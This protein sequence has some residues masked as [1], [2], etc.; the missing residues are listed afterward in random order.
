MLWILAAVVIVLAP[1]CFCIGRWAWTF[2]YLPAR[3]DRL[4]DR[5]QRERAVQIMERVVRA[6]GF[7]WN[8]EEHR[9][10]LAWYYMSA[11]EYGPAA[12]HLRA[13]LD[14]PCVF[15]DEEVDMRLLLADCLEGLG[16]AEAAEKQRRRAEK[17]VRDIDEPWLL[18]S[19]R[20][21]CLRERQR[22]GDAC[23]AYERALRS[24]PEGEVALRTQLMV[25]L[26][27]SCHDAARPAE[28]VQWA[29]KAVATGADGEL[30]LTA[31]QIAA[32]GCVTLG[33]LEE[34][35]RHRHGVFELALKQGD[36]ARAAE[37]LAGIGS[38]RCARG[39]FASAL[40]ACRSAVE[41]SPAARRLAAGVE[42][43]CHRYVGRW[44][45]A[46]AAYDRQLETEP[47]PQ[48]PA[49][50]RFRA[51]NALGRALVDLEAENPAAAAAHLDA[52]Y[53]ELAEDL[54]L[55]HWCGS[56]HAVLH[57]LWGESEAALRL[58]EELETQFDAV[59]SDPESVRGFQAARARVFLLCG[60]LA[61]SR[62]EW[63][64]YLELDPPPASRV[65]ALHYLGECLQG[66]G[67]PE[68]AG[69]AY[70]R[71]VEAGIPSHH[72]ALAAERLRM[73]DEDMQIATGV[74]AS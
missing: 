21:Q 39:E 70:R 17:R 43:E 56:A 2:F 48:P 54:K 1:A 5:G 7:T 11:G 8:R 32:L 14:S 38:I 24:A 65:R 34:A 62:R 28:A 41:V 50:R 58:L 57:A 22:Y 4:F 64:R 23:E 27:L 6:P 9:R 72:A 59:R 45:D 37:C 67:E 49:E 25:S 42:A 10:R 31:R 29:E 33:R 18:Y 16:E 19:R 47:F 69:L 71:A 68:E 12:A 30:L 36:D 26:A 20:G 3:A 44:A 61:R 15:A 35:E 46:H 55:V 66:A 52:A 13:A 53:G 63:E 60:D 74:G 73:I 40:D 51:I